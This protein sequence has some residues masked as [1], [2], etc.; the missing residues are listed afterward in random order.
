MSQF[1][2]RI[3]SVQTSRKSNPKS[4]NRSK[5]QIPSTQLR[6]GPSRPSPWFKLQMPLGNERRLPRYANHSQAKDYPCLHL[7]NSL[8]FAPTDVLPYLLSETLN[9]GRRN[10]TG[11]L[12]GTLI[13]TL[14]GCKVIHGVTCILICKRLNNRISVPACVSSCCFT[15]NL[16]SVK[17]H[18][19]WTC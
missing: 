11:K 19:F 2:E 16:Y 13:Y 10:L 14:A 6:S 5:S 12:R 8:N 15:S 4:S 1:K 18:W 7:T 17:S 9:S 3:Q